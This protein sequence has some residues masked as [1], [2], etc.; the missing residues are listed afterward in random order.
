MPVASDDGL[1]GRRPHSAIARSAQPAIGRTAVR[2]RSRSNADSRGRVEIADG[3][4]PAVPIGATLFSAAA[5]H[6]ADERARAVAVEPAARLRLVDAA[7]VAIFVLFAAAC[8][9]AIAVRL[10]GIGAGRLTTHERLRA[11]AAERAL[12]LVRELTCAEA[13]VVPHAAETSAAVPSGTTFLP[14]ALQAADERRFALR[15]ELAA[16]ARIEGHPIVAAGSDE[17]QADSGSRAS[18]EAHRRGA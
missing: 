6:R 15:V 1:R 5:V 8:R 2:S 16:L 4:V 12:L 17:E 7:A 9:R 3:A 10:A 14:T 18:V 11:V 13:I